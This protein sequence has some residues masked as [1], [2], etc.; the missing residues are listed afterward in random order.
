[1]GSELIC[2]CTGPS[3]AGYLVVDVDL[4]SNCSVK[5]HGGK[6]TVSIFFVSLPPC[7]EPCHQVA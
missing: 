7:T 5:F 4:A 1:M 3:L 2:Q 6:N